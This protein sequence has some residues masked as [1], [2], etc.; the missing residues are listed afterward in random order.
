M[1][2]PDE[3]VWVWLVTFVGIGDIDIGTR[4]YGA[5]VVGYG[6]KNR[7]VRSALSVHQ[8]GKK[9]SERKQKNIYSPC[10][11]RYASSSLRAKFDMDTAVERVA[12][13]MGCGKFPRRCFAWA[14]THIGE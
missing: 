6:S 3:V 7:A 14:D 1:K 5:R 9:Q 12:G 11:H 2:S 13:K 10:K 4:D 8:V